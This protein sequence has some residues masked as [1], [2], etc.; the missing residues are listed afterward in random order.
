MPENKIKNGLQ[1]GLA[2]LRSRIRD[3]ETELRR[4]DVE[5]D[6]QPADRYR[7]LFEQSADAILIIDGETFVD[8]NQATVDM[9]RYNNK[10][11]LLETHP[12]EL[13]PPT[14]PDGRDSYE[15]A[16]EMIAIAFEQGS[17]R[18]EWDHKRA[19]GEVFPVEVLLTPVPDPG[20]TKLH[21]V[22]R[23]ITERKQLESQLRQAQKMEAIGKLAGGIAHDFNNLL[24]AINGNAELLQDE[25][26]GNSDLLDMTRQIRWAGERAAELTRQLLAFSRKQVLRPTVLDLNEIL[27]DVHK[28]LGRLIGEDVRLITQPAQS[29]VLLK[30]DTGQIEQVLINLATNSRDAMPGGGTLTIGVEAHRLEP[31]RANGLLSLESGDYVRLTVEDT[32]EGMDEST[33]NRAFEPFFTTKGPGQGTGLGLST[34]YGI[35]K[36]SGGEVI[37]H[38]EPG[39]GTRVEVWFPLTDEAPARKPDLTAHTGEGGS[40]TVLVVEDESTVSTLVYRLLSR[41]GYRVMMSRNGLEALDLYEARAGEIDLILSDVVMPQ[42]GGAELVRRLRENGHDPLVIFAS[43]YSDSA[44]GSPDQLGEHAGFLQKPYSPRELLHTVR[45]VLDRAKSR[46]K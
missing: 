21:V 11:E 33:K 27:S 34:V 20:G 31:E 37:L 42:M 26:D 13:S 41:Q 38:S 36:Q 25:L 1:R 7:A 12:S 35:V 44:Y 28:L 2:E 39:Q 3:L 16:N 29:P 23:D 4:R 9:L 46:P 43:G 22:W 40:E 14:Q 15:K 45:A 8:C 6:R 5:R 24:V 30:A 19:G 10:Q 17:H 18:F 32:G